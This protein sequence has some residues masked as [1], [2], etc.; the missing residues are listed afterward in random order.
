LNDF[1]VNFVM[2]YFINKFTE[3]LVVTSL[4]YSFYINI[5]EIIETKLGVE[6]GNFK[7]QIWST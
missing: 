2:D 1:I 3:I 5:Y 4:T 6:N 7:K